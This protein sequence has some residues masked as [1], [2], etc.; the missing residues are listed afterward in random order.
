MGL[1][2][3][4]PASRSRRR[5]GEVT[6]MLVQK[7]I[8]FFAPLLVLVVVL[9]AGCLTEEAVEAEF[10]D[11]NYCESSDECVVLYPG[12]PL[13]CWTAVN[14]AEEDRIADL[15]DDF[16]AQQTGAECA[17]DCAAHK[18]PRCLDGECV[19]EAME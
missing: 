15:I 7:T 1:A 14:E 18:D 16:F 17:Y 12:C 9:A 4:V 8:R 6:L 3:S 11:A 13:G 2:P 10:D 19:V 5:D